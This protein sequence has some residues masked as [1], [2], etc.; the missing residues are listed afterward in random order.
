MNGSSY[1]GGIPI[2]PDARPT[3]GLISVA[4]AGAFSR[5][6][7]VGIL[8]RLIVGK[9][10]HHPRLHFFHGTEFV[11]RFDRPVRPTPMGN[12][13]SPATSIGYRSSLMGYG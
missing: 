10:V 2:V 12:C 6:G 1:G 3:D 4:V 13:L 11:V 8:P 5:L 9:H 7:V